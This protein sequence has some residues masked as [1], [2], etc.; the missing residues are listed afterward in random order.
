MKYIIFI[1][2]S[3][4]FLLSAASTGINHLS[5]SISWKTYSGSEIYKHIDRKIES[6]SHGDIEK[7]ALLYSKITKN[8]KQ[9]NNSTNAAALKQV[10]I[11][12]NTQAQEELKIFY[13]TTRK[14]ILWYTQ[15]QLPIEAYVNG[16]PQKWY[17]WIFANMHGGYEYGTYLSA[18][19]LK[20]KLEQ[21]NKTGW[22]I[23]P[24]SNPDWLEIYLKNG[25]EQDYYISG[26]TNAN[27]VDLNRNFC[28]SD[29]VLNWFIKNGIEVDTWIWGCGSEIETQIISNT[30]SDYLFHQIISLHSAG[31]IIFIPDY[32]FD[33]SGVTDFAARVSNILPDYD[34]DISYSSQK[35]KDIKIQKYEVNERWEADYTGTLENYIYEKYQIPTLLIELPEHGKID[36]NL[37]DLTELFD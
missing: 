18:L 2:F 34:F 16:D 20:D 35:E 3:C 5:I 28:S 15:N 12:G 11:Y 31:N 23:I 30:L 27:N 25:D 17:F 19:A 10:I 1:F 24:T 22:F 26:R 4:I 14:I 9:Y 13:A 33:D 6:Y 8:L 7:K 29:F 37:L 21:E 32:S 36:R